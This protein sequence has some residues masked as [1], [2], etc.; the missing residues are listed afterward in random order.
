LG[1]ALAAVGLVLAAARD[2]QKSVPLAPPGD[3]AA[4][5]WKPTPVPEGETVALVID[6][7]NGARRE[8]DALPWSAGMTVGDL[9]RTARDFRPAVQFEQSGTGDGAFLTS[10]E[11]VA[12]EGAGGRFW[13]YEV[14]GRFG[15]VSFDAQQLQAG[16]R[17][18]WK[19]RRGE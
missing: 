13:F 16:Q 10:L 19:F 4:E 14:D 15:T 8:F 3:N 17:V 12:H 18:L 6:F 2:N 1:A 9:L 11:G 5:H 7:G